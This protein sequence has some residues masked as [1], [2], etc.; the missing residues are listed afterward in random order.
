MR[1]TPRVAPRAIRE[2]QARRQHDEARQRLLRRV[3]E[4]VLPPILARQTPEA[5]WQTTSVGVNGARATRRAGGEV[6]VVAR[7]DLDGNA[8]RY[9]CAHH[10]APILW[11]E[12][13]VAEVA[14]GQ[15]KRRAPRGN[16]VQRR[17]RRGCW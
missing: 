13:T 10:A 2:Y 8:G 5:I 6:L 9:M 11:R 7:H 15:V 14:K 16:P 4:E 1:A 3:I 12:V 17:G